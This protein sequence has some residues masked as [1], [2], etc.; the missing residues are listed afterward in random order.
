[1][2][3]EAIPQNAPSE[4][5]V[6]TTPPNPVKNDG[7]SGWTMPEP[8]FRKTSGYLPQGYENKFG[9]VDLKSGADETES[10]AEMPAPDIGPQ[11]DIAEHSDS[12]AAAAPAVAAPK[13]GS[14]AKVVLTILGLLLALGL[15][16]VFIAVIYILFLMP[17]SDGT[18]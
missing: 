6:N 16:V 5:D 4:D 11:P 1:M 9:E 2:S 17:K 14:A 18:F 15:V 10:T 8:V 7:A 12:A 3:E 13:K